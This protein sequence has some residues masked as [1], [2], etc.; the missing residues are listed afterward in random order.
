VSSLVEENICLYASSDH[1]NNQ[2]S[3]ILQQTGSVLHTHVIHVL[4]AEKLDEIGATLE[5]CASKPLVLLALQ[6][7]KTAS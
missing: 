7:N 4:N 2:I 3:E 6:T 1:N 5:G